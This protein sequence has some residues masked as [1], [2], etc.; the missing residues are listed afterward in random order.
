MLTAR[1]R[2]LDI[3][4]GFRSGAS[5][6]LAKPINREELMARMA[7][8]LQIRDSVRQSNELSVIRRD[9]DIAHRIHRNAILRE[10]PSVDNAVITLR[11][12]PMLKMGGDFYD[13]IPMGAGK[14][15]AVVADVSG[16]GISAALI[17]AMLKMAFAFHAGKGED[18]ASL[19]RAV[20][21]SVF[22]YLEGMFITACCACVDT[23]RGV[24]AYS[25]AGH[26]PPLLVRKSGELLVLDGGE[27]MPL[28]LDENP[29]Y[30]TAAVSLERG[31]RVV[32]YTDG[33]IEVRN[34]EGRM[35]GPEAFLDLVRASGGCDSE[36]L[37][38][39]IIDSV[40][41]WKGKG[42]DGALDDDVTLMLL[43][44][45]ES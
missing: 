38:D 24:M 36:V 9:I 33:I 8:L 21:G 7:N 13:I 22:H 25:C 15:A 41:A 28:G 1:S 26:W 19:L 2:G 11:Y 34:S 16:H 32:L 14:F 37:A 23:V 6:Y 10:A 27:G 20:N 12:L 3:A 43:D 4:A 39:R 35:M 30:E 40:N 45:R 5:D 42:G 18:P 29:L 44:I 17:C 31:D